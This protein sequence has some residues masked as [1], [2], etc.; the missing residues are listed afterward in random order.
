MEK[1][2]Y[3][4]AS[5]QGVLDSF[6]RGYG[7]TSAEF[8]RAHLNNDASM[9]RISGFHRHAWAGFYVAWE[10]MSDNGFASR[11]KRDLELA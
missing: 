4:A 6:E 1:R 9:E 10:R 2:Y 5:L 8:Y 11:V 7:M 3:N